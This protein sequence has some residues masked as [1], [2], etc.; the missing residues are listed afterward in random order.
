MPAEEYRSLRAG[1][2]ALR[3]IRVFVAWLFVVFPATPAAGAELCLGSGSGAW[4]DAGLGAIRGITIGPIESGLHP[5][6]GYG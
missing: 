5:G 4:A 2:G 3:R 6:K 1:Q